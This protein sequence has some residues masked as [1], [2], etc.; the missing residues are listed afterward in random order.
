[1]PAPVDHIK[2]IRTNGSCT[3]GRNAYN[4]RLAK[5]HGI[6]ERF[7]INEVGAVDAGSLAEHSMGYGSAPPLQGAVF[8][9]VYTARM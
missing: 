1:V 7:E 6:V 9:V 8:D 5:G 3:R 4:E 2:T